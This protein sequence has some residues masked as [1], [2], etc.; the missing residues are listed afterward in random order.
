MIGKH[1]WSDSL[2]LSRYN[3][4]VMLLQLGNEWGTVS[5]GRARQMEITSKWVGPRALAVY[6]AS[7]QY[8]LG[9]GC[10]QI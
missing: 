5:N 6:W 1:A 8:D 9:S 4:K 10:I 2:T 7:S 3:K